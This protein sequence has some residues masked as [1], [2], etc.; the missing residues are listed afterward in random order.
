[1]KYAILEADTTGYRL[2]QRYVDYD[3]AA[4]INRVRRVRHPAADYITQFML[5]QNEPAWSKQS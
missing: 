4:V 2:R 1:V 3:H 5:G